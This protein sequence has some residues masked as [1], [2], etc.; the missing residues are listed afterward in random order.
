MKYILI[1]YYTNVRP[2]ETRNLLFSSCY[3]R[4]DF[5]IV[6]NI[7]QFRRVKIHGNY[8]YLQFYSKSE[9]FH[10]V[11]FLVSTVRV[12]SSIPIVILQL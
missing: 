1:N 5:E 8:D 4:R 11:V 10:L 2:G 6:R 3:G 9:T 12:L 7:K